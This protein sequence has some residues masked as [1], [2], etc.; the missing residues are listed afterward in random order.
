[1][2]VLARPGFPVVPAN[3]P[4]L[5]SSLRIVTIVAENDALGCELDEFGAAVGKSGWYGNIAAEY[6]LGPVRPH[7]L[8]MGPP[9]GPRVG[10]NGA[11]T[12]FRDA[13]ARAYI[14]R[15]IQGRDDAAPDG[16]T[17]YLLYLPDGVAIA[18]GDTVNADCSRP[19]GYHGHAEDRSE[20]GDAYAVV[21]RCA[22][23]SGESPLD[24]LTRIASHEIAEAA[25][26]PRPAV[27]DGFELLLPH[28]AEEWNASPWL[29]IEG[30]SS[31]EIG[32]LCML[33]R[34]REGAFVYQRIFSNAAA[35]RG[36]DPCVP[37]LPGAY[38]NVTTAGGWFSAASG[39]TVTIPVTGWSTA[40]TSDWIVSATPSSTNDPTKRMT[41]SLESPTTATLRGASFA[42]LGSGRSANLVVQVPADAPSG[43]WGTVLLHSF[44]VDADGNA[45]DGEDFEHEWIVGVHVP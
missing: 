22:A 19:L 37:A 12:G 42:T 2:A 23:P 24:Q 14:S 6:G 39:G 10:A 31:A 27:G 41:T 38:Y 29:Q 15:A 30:A 28:E 25:T 40:P 33:T 8:V 3:G 20:Q 17:L 11:L 5:L 34:A 18:F 32:D 44:R 9:I 1:M 7:V 13:D 43:S 36:G 45:P 35:T 4:D 16:Q 26:D 21:Q